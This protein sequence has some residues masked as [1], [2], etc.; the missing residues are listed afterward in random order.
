MKRLK[1]INKRF[2]LLWL[3][4]PCTAL[5]QEGGI[6]FTQDTTWQQVLADAKA[7][8]KYIFVDCYTTWCGPCKRMDAE[9]YPDKTVGDYFN[10]HF[11]SL[12]LQM[13]KTPTDAAAVKN[14]YYTA[15]MFTR[16]YSINAFPTFMFFDPD[17]KPAHKVSGSEDAK[18]F[19][20]TGK[21]AQD[22]GKQYYAILNNFQPG[23]L[24][25]AEE[26]GLA[27]SFSFSDKVLARKITLDYL[28]RIPKK[29]LSNPDNGMLM[30]QF[31]D[32]PQ[33]LDMAIGYIKKNGIKNNLRFMTA[34]SK[35]PRVHQLSIDYIN[36]LTDKQL[37]E[38]RNLDFISN[39]YQE[40][41]IR[42]RAKNLINE[43][44]EKDI[45]RTSVVTFIS[46]FTDT[47]TD[48]GFT[49]IYQHP[50][51]ADA[52][53]GH[54]GF[55]RRFIGILIYK[56]ILKMPIQNGIKTHIDPDWRELSK[57]VFQNFPLFT[58]AAA[59]SLVLSSEFYYYLKVKDAEGY[60][61]SVEEA[62]NKFPP[63][64]KG[65]S[66]D[67]VVGG[68]Q[69]G[70]PHCDAW[71]LNHVAWFSFL[72]F[73]DATVL[74]KAVNWADMAILYGAGTNTLH[75]YMDTKANLLYKIGDIKQAEEMEQQTL[76]ERKKA[77][78]DPND[79]FVKSYTETLYKFESGKPTWPVK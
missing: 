42:K 56:A 10:D 3:L 31:Q 20:Q 28:T 1:Q 41:D 67:D 24:D 19:I 53:L 60:A 23:K 14:W 7:Q 59:D 68:Q 62:L 58:E 15:G 64:A 78:T 38:D 77:T 57:N 12:K 79:L 8:H 25:T 73:N 47:V 50:A 26:K 13:D 66:F 71:G 43:L 39:F 2:L 27:R 63:S 52:A 36:S 4:L 48:R 74:R 35:Q 21:E 29:Q 75:Q 49:L 65:T 33:I 9:V 69:L 72:T 5:S 34:L 40:P 30:V 22:A 18:N 11:I 6:E 32:D 70:A 76:A 61:K 46:H 51:E 54:S 16:N 45:R 17:G 37:S 55:P 44:P